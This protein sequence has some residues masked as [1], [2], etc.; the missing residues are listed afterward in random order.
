MTGYEKDGKYYI[1]LTL[2]Q[3]TIVDKDDYGYLTQ[4]FWQ[5][6]P[7]RTKKNF[8]AIRNVGWDNQGRRLKVSMHREIMHFPEGLEV[9]HINGDP[10]DN[11][12][13]N[14]RI[15]TH[16]ENVRNQNRKS[17]KAGH[18]GIT[19][20]GDKWRA[21]IGVNYEKVHIGVYETRNEAIAAYT[22]ASKWYHKEF[23]N[24]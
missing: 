14:L 21:Q 9:D 4:F 3:E 16:A 18:K 23:S 19:K 11:R 6:R 2:G 12:K 20:H 7:T 17:N 22:T 10:L 1:C 15:C 5:A 13:H 8:Y 24:V